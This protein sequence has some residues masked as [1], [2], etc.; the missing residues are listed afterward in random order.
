MPGPAEFRQVMRTF[1]TGVTVVAARDG[2]G[3]PVG[4]TVNAF[5]SVSLDPPMVLICIDRRSSS[6]DVLVE[7]GTFT[8]NVL[9]SGQEALAER[10]AA[11]PADGRFAGVAWREGPNGAPVLD[12]TAAWLAC[13]LEAVHAGGDHSILVA[14]VEDAWAAVTP[15]L[16]FFRGAYGEVGT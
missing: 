12:G 8:V 2:E 11:D 7:R 5:T 13:A 6:H 1:P 4:L 16:V 15:S 9:A 10:F 14:R 3:L